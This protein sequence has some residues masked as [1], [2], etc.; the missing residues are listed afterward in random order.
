MIY[1]IDPKR[2]PDS[3]GNF[4]TAKVMVTTILNLFAT[5]NMTW[6][7]KPSIFN[8][9]IFMKYIYFIKQT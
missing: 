6:D 8:S 9:K 1:N 7:A 2:N 3:L 5:L 4:R